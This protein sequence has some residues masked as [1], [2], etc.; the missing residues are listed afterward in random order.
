MPLQALSSA[1]F[2][3]FSQEDKISEGAIFSVDN[4]LKEKNQDLIEA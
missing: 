3:P 4:L 2:F 1:K